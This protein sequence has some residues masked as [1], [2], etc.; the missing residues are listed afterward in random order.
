MKKIEVIKD[1][2]IN[3]KNKQIIH[4]LECPRCHCIFK[5]KFNKLDCSLDDYSFGNIFI[6]CPQCNKEIRLFLDRLINGN[7]DTNI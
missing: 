6:N 1:G 5:Y 4:I 2:L 7:Y 3:Q